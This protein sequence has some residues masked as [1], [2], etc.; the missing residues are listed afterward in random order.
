MDERN[1]ITARELNLNECLD[2]HSQYQTILIQ[3][4]EWIL[5]VEF[6]RKVE[7]TLETIPDPYITEKQM[8]QVHKH[9]ATVMS[10]FG[11]PQIGDY[12]HGADD[13]CKVVERTFDVQ[14]KTVTITVS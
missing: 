3:G 9:I 8:L 13:L 5:K 11:L 14:S 7:D 12:V 6:V 10:I 4:L 2:N 1:L